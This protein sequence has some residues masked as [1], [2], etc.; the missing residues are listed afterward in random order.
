MESAYSGW[1]DTAGAMSQE[2]VE[3]RGGG[4]RI[5]SDD[6]VGGNTCS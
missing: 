6:D 3:V 5:A 2:N 4:Y 1:R